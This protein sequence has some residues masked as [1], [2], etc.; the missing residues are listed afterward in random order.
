MVSWPKPTTLKALQGF[1]GLTGYYRKFIQNFGKIAGP[2]T[3]MLKKDSFVW[4]PIAEEAFKKLKEAM[5]KALVLALPDFSKKFIVE[6]DA[7]GSG[8]G[9]VLMQDRP[10][11][12]FSQ[13][14][15]GKNLLLSTYEKEILA[16]VLA[17]QKWRPYL[18]GHQFIVRTDH[19]SLKYLW[20]QRITTVAQ[21]RWLYKLMG[22]DFV[23]E[24]KQ[25]KENVVAD[26]L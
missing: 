12:F 26:I 2:L 1:L 24:Y 3:K 22:Y 15:Q 5:T 11:A 19:R 6:C 13:A 16:L 14:L 23:I 10:I 9:A 18:L 25:G 17:V 21:Q 20:K 8:V 4:T 7:S